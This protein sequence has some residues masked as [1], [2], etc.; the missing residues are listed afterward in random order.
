MADGVHNQGPINKQVNISGSTIQGNV[1]VHADDRQI[2]RRLTSRQPR[3]DPNEPFLGRAAD[4][5]A[6]EAELNAGHTT[7]LINGTGGV[8]KTTLAI[9]FFARAVDKYQHLA[10]IE[11]KIVEDSTAPAGQPEL[12]T[13]AQAIVNAGVLLRHLGVDTE[14]RA[15]K[16]VVTDA[17]N[18][19]ANLPAGDGR[20]NLLVIDNADLDLDDWRDQLP[21]AP[22]WHV[23]IT[24]RRQLRAGKQLSIESL[25]PVAA[26][27]LF[28][29]HYHLERNDA[30]VDALLTDIDHH[31]LTLELIAKTARRCR[32]TLAQLS[33]AY[34]ARGLEL[35][36]RAKITVA[37]D[38][39]G[40]YERL[41]PYLQQTFALA[42][43]DEGKTTVLR[44]LLCFGTA[45][46]HPDFLAYL[47]A[48]PKDDYDRRDALNDTLNELVATGW[49]LEEFDAEG[50]TVL[51]DWLRGGYRL[52]RV[53]MALLWPALMEEENFAAVTQMIERLCKYLDIDE[54]S[55]TESLKDRLPYLET[56]M[57]V[58]TALSPVFGVR[59]EVIELYDTVAVLLYY[60]GD[61]AQARIHVRAAL[62]G[63][64]TEKDD[65]R[66]ARLRS[67][68]GDIEERLGN[69]PAAAELLE[70]A[71]AVQIE[72]FGGQH[73][74]V[75]KSRYSLATIKQN[76]DDYPA[77]VVLLE[78]A[79]AAN[80]K[81]FDVQHPEVQNSR[82]NLATVRY[83]LG[84][85]PAAAEL[86]EQ[87]L[88]AE[89]EYFGNQHSR[90][91]I[92][93]SNLAQVYNE[94]KRY[95]EAIELGQSALDA[96]LAYHGPDHPDV[97]IMQNNLAYIISHQHRYAEAEQLIAT[98][99]ATQLKTLGAEHPNTKRSAR[100]L[101]DIRQKLKE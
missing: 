96:L 63:S 6:I 2:A 72:H 67:N 1:V 45:T 7:V 34:S 76:L 80:I 29:E 100:S 99:Y 11:Q 75:Q 90:V 64:L 16:D 41:F 53:V 37:H 46:V 74:E 51:P 38:M 89:I 13:F 21:T 15:T 8:G 69:Y 71:L 65:V 33:D 20:P 10:W 9:N 87:A 48:Y 3:P 98:A 27:E 49:L 40:R 97:A 92:S 62:N 47:L 77:A 81:Y 25:S 68:L 26:K 84:D 30:I 39:D 78:Q 19:L 4:L 95:Q 17:L 52:H 32:M 73:P 5:A 18:A 57:A 61:Y 31:T 59:A 86:L 85:Y 28:Y 60:R 36:R 82:S 50:T 79:L 66:T 55:Q 35:G 22:D 23:L 14:Q 24:S 54:Y 70:K 88:A 12:A 58:L 43:L 94:Q 83:A 93:R 56:A 101:E 44:Y 91:Q 42:D